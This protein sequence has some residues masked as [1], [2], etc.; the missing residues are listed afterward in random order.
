MAPTPMTERVLSEHVRVIARDL[1]LP[2]AYH[3][4]ISVKSAPGFLDWIFANLRGE[5]MFRELKSATGK[6]TDDQAVWINA[7]LAGGHDV[8]IWR[9]EDLFSHR[10][11]TELAHLARLP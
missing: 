3:T 4:H 10:I 1:R 2:L 6:I 7:L 9:P 8:G 11:H 5:I